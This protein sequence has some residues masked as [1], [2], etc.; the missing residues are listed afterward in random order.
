MLNCLAVGIGG[1][2]GS[3]ARYLMGFVPLKPS[4]GFPVNTLLINVIGSFIIGLVVSFSTR[5]EGINPQL[6]LLLKVG[7]CGGFT[8]FSTFSFETVKLIEN[9]AYGMVLLYVLLSVC[10]GISMI[11]L[12]QWL[13][14]N[15][16]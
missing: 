7:F 4:E 16:F 11:M 12:S 2:M 14:Q 3:V 1:F 9:G 8:T 5:N 15:V 6:V 13:V 10:L